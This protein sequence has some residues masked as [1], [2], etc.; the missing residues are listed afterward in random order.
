MPKLNKILW[1]LVI[2]FIVVSIIIFSLAILLVVVTF[3]SLYG[4]YRYYFTKK[5]TKKFETRQKWYTSGGII[6]LPK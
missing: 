4:I 1:S 5:R 2:L 6:D 3:A